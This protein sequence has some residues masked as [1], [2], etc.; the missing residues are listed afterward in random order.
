MAKIDLAREAD[1]VEPVPAE[2][3]TAKP[4][5]PAKKSGQKPAVAKPPA[6]AA[7]AKTAKERARELA[8]DKY[9]VEPAAKLS[10]AE[11][12]ALRRQVW[13]QLSSEITPEHDA[14]LDA[15]A[16]VHGSRKA[17]IAYLIDSAELPQP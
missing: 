14:K 10:R 17:A 2:Q 15:M 5:R 16:V 11:Q 4:K 3:P 12:M 1:D 13:V 8:A 9:G 7:K 6:A